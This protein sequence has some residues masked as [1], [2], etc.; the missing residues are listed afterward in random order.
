[1][2]LGKLLALSRILRQRMGYPHPSQD[3]VGWWPLSHA[4]CRVGFCGVRAGDS[5]P[6]GSVDPG[7]WAERH[8]EGV[9]SWCKDPGAFLT[10]IA[11]L[12]IGLVYP[13]CLPCFPGGKEVC[14]Q[15]V[16]SGHTED[17]LSVHLENLNLPT[18]SCS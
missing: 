4:L 12:S 10:S 17:L 1:M 13:G 2:D 15:Q 18:L 14:P 3:P 16:S 6:P 5:T 11:I 8:Q 7:F 9:L